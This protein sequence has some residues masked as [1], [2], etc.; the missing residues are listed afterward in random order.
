MPFC[1]I[2]QLRDIKELADAMIEAGASNQ[3]LSVGDTWSRVMT[4]YARLRDAL[5]DRLADMTMRQEADPGS[6]IEPV[7]RTFEQEYYP[8]HIHGPDAV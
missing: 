4:Y 3:R 5:S 2:T 7:R 1:D 6:F 8:G